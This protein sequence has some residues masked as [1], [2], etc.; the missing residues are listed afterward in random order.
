MYNT[1]SGNGFN[2]DS[3]TVTSH[4]PITVK[5][6]PLAANRQSPTSN[7]QLPTTGVR[8]STT[9]IQPP[10]ANRQ[11]P[12]SNIQLPAAETAD[13]SHKKLNNDSL[14]KVRRQQIYLK[15][16][17]NA[18]LKTATKDSLIVARKRQSFLKDSLNTVRKA[19]LKD[20]LMAVKKQQGHMKDSLLAVRK[21]TK[22]SLLSAKKSGGSK[23]SLMASQKMQQSKDSLQAANKTN[24]I[25]DSLL[26]V[27]KANFLR[28][29]PAS[30]NSKRSS[31]IGHRSSLVPGVKKLR[32]VS[33]KISR[34][35]VFLDIGK[36][37]M[38]DT[39]TLFVYFE[40]SDTTGLKGLVRS[41]NPDTSRLTNSMAR[42]SPLKPGEAVCGQVATEADTEFLRSAILKANSEQE[43]IS[44]ANNAFALKCFSVSQVRLLTSLLVSDKARYRL[45]DAAHYHIADPDHFTELVDMLTDK[46]FQRK[47]LMMAEKRS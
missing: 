47:F 23:D 21:A 41:K 18:A 4:L 7:V 1:Y 36:D 38:I 10:T 37:G 28:D 35:I 45:M 33:L 19:A 5:G 22:D 42:K 26:A 31:V 39:V 27:N 34:K 6:Q 15:D 30:V 11:P 8:P 14:L 2:R 20:S 12:T 43:K 44:V 3:L 46:N 9:D 13:G 32:E 24:A 17:L 25:R 16:S 40:T 29:S